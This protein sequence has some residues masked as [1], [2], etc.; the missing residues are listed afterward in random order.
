MTRS[1]HFDILKQTQFSMS[2]SDDDD[3]E[4]SS[5]VNLQMM[6]KSVRQL[7]SALHSSLGDEDERKEE[8]FTL[9]DEDFYWPK[10]NS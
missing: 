3:D 5:C 8:E 7:F 1:V 2:G 10:Q 6:Y 9:R 4:H